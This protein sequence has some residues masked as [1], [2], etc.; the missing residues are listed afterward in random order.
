MD[1]TADAVPLIPREVLIGNPERVSPA[2]SPDGKRLAY[3]APDE[4][5]LNVWVGQVGSGDFAPFTK[6]RERGI[7]QF[8][9]A[10]D[11]RHVLYLQD[12]GGDEN[13][14]LASVD[15]DTGSKADLTPFP[16][17]QVQ[18]LSVDVRH[19]DEIIIGINKDNPQLHDPYRLQLSTGELT[20]ICD[21]PGF[22]GWVIDYEHKVRGGVAMTPDGGAV[23]VV[24]ASEDAEWAPL[25]QV[26]SDDALSTDP[27]GFSRDGRSLLLISP[28]N[29]NT[30]RLL[31][32]DLETKE[33]TVLAE[34][35]E[36]DVVAGLVNRE[37]RELDAVGYMKDR[38]EWQ[39]L[40]AGVQ[41]DFDALRGLSP[42]DFGVQ[43]RDRADTVWLVA[44]TVDDGAVRY[45]AWDRPTQTGSFLFEHRSDLGQYRMAKMEPFE[46]TASDGLTVHGYVTFPLDVPHVN[47]PTVLN[48]HG[49]PWHRDTWGFNP[50]AQWLANRGYACIQI[51]FRGSLGYGK[52]FT[53]AG[54]REWGGKMHQDILDGLDYA[55][56]QGWTD[57]ERV[58]I[59]GGSYG[60]YE[61]LV[62]AT[63]N[64]ERFRCAVALCGPSNLISFIEGVPEY[65][66]PMLDMLHKRVGNPET[67]REFLL[68]RSPLTHVDNV[69]IPM[70]I[71]QGANDPRVRQQ[72]SEQFVD[73]MKAKGIDHEYICFA[74]EGHGFVRPENRLEFYRV[75]ERFLATHLGGRAEP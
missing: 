19:E 53:N 37:T 3:L 51:N 54:D 18:I 42:G 34:D 14:R 10:P 16:D 59:Y 23:I 66:K 43:G 75:A 57:P 58:A 61:T 4:G 71:A 9:F 65:W 7:Q 41:K 21:N 74:D 70:L 15:L 25:L 6:D 17:V 67:E 56:A 20:K 31:R 39:V 12:S 24:R 72:E 73:A 63:S 45:Y 64:P 2:I 5:V 50:E 55:I 46:F 29:A 8:F 44:Y 27:I 26:A 35:P 33:T 1:A 22:V 13:W 47:L 38:L 11:N 36:A 68:E 30:A 60:G 48:V 40:D 32:L 49:G 28:E 62:G 52:A 69:S